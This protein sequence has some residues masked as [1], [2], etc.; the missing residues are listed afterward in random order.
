MT[1]NVYR[2]VRCI[3]TLI[4]FT[5]EEEVEAEGAGLAGGDAVLPGDLGGWE[6]LSKW[7]W[8]V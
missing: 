5:L 1:I 2:Y 4:M 7:L 6:N 3:R 8:L